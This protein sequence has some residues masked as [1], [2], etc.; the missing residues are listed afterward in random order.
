MKV[1]EEEDILGVVS[2]LYKMDLASLIFWSGVRLGVQ[3]SL[4]C[5]KLS[6]AQRLS[7]AMSKM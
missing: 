4:E 7:H 2:V 5:C 3:W 6:K 1:D